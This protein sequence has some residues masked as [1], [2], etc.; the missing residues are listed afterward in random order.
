MSK[1][2]LDWSIYENDPATEA[3]IRAAERAENAGGAISERIIRSFKGQDPIPAPPR[4]S[5]GNNTE[6][7]LENSRATPVF[8]RGHYFVGT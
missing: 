3:E 5:Q 4:G 7:W 1:I 6:R 8:H 2:F